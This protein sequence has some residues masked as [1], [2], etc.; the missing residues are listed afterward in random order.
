MPMQ[1][2]VYGVINI[3]TFKTLEKE[4]LLQSYLSQT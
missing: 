4:R 3:N 2:I 1:V